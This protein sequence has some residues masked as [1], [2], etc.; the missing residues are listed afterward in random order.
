MKPVLYNENHETTIMWVNTGDRADV[1]I[2][3]STNKL[4]GLT[5]DEMPETGWFYK[6]KF[7]LAQPAKYTCKLR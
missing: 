2:K 3:L 4:A 5:S 1:R 6:K 7:S